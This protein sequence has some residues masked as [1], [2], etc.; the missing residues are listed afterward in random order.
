M[1][2]FCVKGGYNGVTGGEAQSSP[3]TFFT[4]KFLLTYRENSAKKERENGGKWRRKE[5]NLRIVKGKAGNK[6][7]WK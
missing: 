2:G 6:K 1:C 5:G 7:K 3:L 4:A